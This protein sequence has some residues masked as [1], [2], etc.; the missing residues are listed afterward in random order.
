VL[1]SFQS[2]LLQTGLW[3]EQEAGASEVRLRALD[4][5]PESWLRWWSEW[6]LHESVSQ[7]AR[8][9]LARREGKS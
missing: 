7:M 4:E 3:L 8:F 2:A 5:V 1:H 9:E 6:S